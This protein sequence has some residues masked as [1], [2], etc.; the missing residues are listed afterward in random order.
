[1]IE[2][3][4]I[5]QFEGMRGNGGGVAMFIKGKVFGGDTGYLYLGSYQM[6]GDTVKAHVNVTRFL[7]DIPSVL[8]V[9]GDFELN[10]VG[11]LDGDVING[12][13]SLVNSQAAGIAVKLTKRAKLPE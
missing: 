8:G 10:I 5:V 3:F 4:W 7:P 9:V 1:M 11:K 2:G 13:G 6:Q 12:T